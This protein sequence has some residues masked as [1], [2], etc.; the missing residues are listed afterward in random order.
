MG[1]GGCVG[2][3][4]LLRGQQDFDGVAPG[5]VSDD[6]GGLRLELDPELSLRLRQAAATQ[7]RPPLALVHDL[8]TD[9]LEQARR[10]RQAQAV[11]RQLTPRQ[12]QVTK[13]TTLGYTNHQIANALVV[14]P[15]TVKTHIRHVLEKFDIASKAD[16]RVLLLDLKVRWWDADP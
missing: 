6:P 7:G 16:L 15:E 8:L 10:R 13:L 1:S 11:L 14:S 9:G 2:L 4:G 5:R 12:Q 3:L